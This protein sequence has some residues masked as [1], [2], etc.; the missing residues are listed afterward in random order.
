METLIR[1]PLRGIAQSDCHWQQGSYR[2]GRVVGTTMPHSLR[3]SVTDREDVGMQSD[4]SAGTLEAGVVFRQRPAPDL[5]SHGFPDCLSI[6][7][8]AS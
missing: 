5:P 2:P 6:K 8:R 1:P 3:L 4:S 7:D